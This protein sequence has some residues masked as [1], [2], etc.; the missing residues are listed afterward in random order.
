M[1]V[2]TPGLLL[3][4]LPPEGQPAL[5]AAPAVDLDAEASRT[6]QNFASASGHVAVQRWRHSASL[7]A[8][9]RSAR[10]T[11]QQCS[12]SAALRCPKMACRHV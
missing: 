11:W 2:D 6:I 1:G 4:H 10:D 9:L 7:V 5:G 12:S 8:A 3:L